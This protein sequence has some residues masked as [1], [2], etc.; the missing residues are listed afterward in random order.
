MSIDIN[1]HEIDIDT[2]S[3]QNE[4]DLC[5]IK[6]K[7]KKLKDLEKKI[8]Q[9]KY[10]DAALADK[11][12]KDYEK[13]KKVILDENIQAKLNNKIDEVKTQLD[14]SINEI[15]SQMDNKA[16]LNISNLND[17]IDFSIYAEIPF[18]NGFT[19]QQGACTTIFLCRVHKFVYFL[20]ISN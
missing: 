13:L 17:K 8:T 20:T 10:I 15:N 3:K 14:N 16:S 19:V 7:N 9:I 11:L 6:K 4:L 18:P 2:L 1:K 5:S 12:K